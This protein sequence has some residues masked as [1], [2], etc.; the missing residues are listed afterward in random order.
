MLRNAASASIW[1][2]ALVPH[3]VA[4]WRSSRRATSF[5]LK[6]GSRAIRFRMPLN[7]SA[8]EIDQALGMIEA[9]L[10]SRAR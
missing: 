6:S 1:R 3:S 7:V 4:L 2:W 8:A 10:P 9:S 5:A